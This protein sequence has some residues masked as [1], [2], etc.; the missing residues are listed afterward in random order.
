ML[1]TVANLTNEFFIPEKIRTCIFR[2][3]P[4]VENYDTFAI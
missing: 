4:V 2:H 1:I 3:H